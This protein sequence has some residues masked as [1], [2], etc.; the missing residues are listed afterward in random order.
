MSKPFDLAA[1][2][3]GEPICRL[4]GQKLRFICHDVKTKAI[5]VALNNEG[6]ESL[7]IYHESGKHSHE[8][9]GFENFDLMM[10][11][12][13][14][15]QF[16]YDE[17]I[18]NPSGWRLETRDGCLSEFIGFSG[19]LKEK[20]QVLY[21]FVNSDGDWGCSGCNKK[22]EFCDWGNHALDLFMIEVT[23]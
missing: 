5:V 8:L 19:K 3:R 21:I 10:Y 16:D 13:I 11:E 6:T 23:L 9:H 17:Y 22:G 2:Q 4:N 14:R 15:K 1:A 7:L 12:P 18:K 20:S